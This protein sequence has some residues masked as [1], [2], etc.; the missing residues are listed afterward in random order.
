VPT[1]RLTASVKEKVERFAI[2]EADIKNEDTE[3]GK[4]TF[5][6]LGTRLVIE[7]G[8]HEQVFKR[9]GKIGELAWKTKQNLT[10]RGAAKAEKPKKEAEETKKVRVT[11]EKESGGTLRKTKT[12]E[13]ETILSASLPDRESSEYA[14]SDEEGVT[15]KKRKVRKKADSTEITSD[16]PTPTFGRRRQSESEREYEKRKERQEALIKERAAERL[17]K[18]KKS[19]SVSEP[20][21]FSKSSTSEIDAGDTGLGDCSIEEAPPLSPKKHVAVEWTDDQKKI[22]YSSFARKSHDYAVYISPDEALKRAKELNVYD[23]KDPKRIFVS[24]PVFKVVA[25]PTQMMG[26]DGFAI[27][28]I[29]KIYFQDRAG[30]VQA[31]ML[32]IIYHDNSNVEPN[33]FVFDATQ[34]RDNIVPPVKISQDLKV[35]MIIGAVTTLLQIL[36]VVTSYYLTTGITKDSSA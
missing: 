14:P 10:M 3:R 17:A 34:I 29:K 25:A 30:H 8:E 26:K 5:Y 20:S 1:D 12:R 28:G 7:R 9:K 18:S 32:E 27:K 19:T 36:Q 33:D 11:I 22:L 31:G 24:C 23:P 2:F 15:F 35:P 4:R 6:V 21:T 16:D 13:L